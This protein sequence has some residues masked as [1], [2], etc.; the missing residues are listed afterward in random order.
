M[1]QDRRKE[2]ALTRGDL[3]G[4]DKGEKSAEVIVVTGNEP[5]R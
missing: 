1:P 3:S 4:N 2:D 5:H